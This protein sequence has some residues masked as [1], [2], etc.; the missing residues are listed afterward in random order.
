M[1]EYSTAGLT[2]GDLKRILEV[3]TTAGLT[4]DAIV[5]IAKD[6]EGNDFSPLAS[7]DSDAAYRAESSYAGEVQHW[8]E[9]DVD[10]LG[11]DRLTW[12]EWYAAAQADGCLPCLV[13]W[14]TN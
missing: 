6:S 12:S 3:A 5:I 2:I 13:L 1:S 9:D 10:D 7:W 11:L 8:D 14:P 4:D